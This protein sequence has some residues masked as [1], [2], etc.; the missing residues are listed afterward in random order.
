MRLVGINMLSCSLFDVYGGRQVKAMKI[1]R[2]LQ[3]VDLSNE[4]RHV[5]RVRRFDAGLWHFIRSLSYR[6]PPA[7]S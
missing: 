2:V 1:R 6:I 3:E 5:P 4:V 7:G